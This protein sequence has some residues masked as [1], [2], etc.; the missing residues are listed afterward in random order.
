MISGGAGI[1]VQVVLTLKLEYSTT[2]LSLVMLKLTE[3]SEQNQFLPSHF[4]K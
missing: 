4:R 3:I 2:L 1:P